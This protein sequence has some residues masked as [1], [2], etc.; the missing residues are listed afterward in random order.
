[1]ITEDC[2]R[3]KVLPLPPKNPTLVENHQPLS[4]LNMKLLNTTLI[5]MAGAVSAGAHAVPV[6]LTP[7]AVPTVVN[8]FLGA[9]RDSDYSFAASVIAADAV[10]TTYQIHCESGLLNMP[11]F[12]T[13]TCD[14]NDPVRCLCLHS[15]RTPA[16]IAPALDRH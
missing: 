6:A 3:Y 5:L 8:L 1:M 12:P 11:G 9:K 13:T 14:Q 4:N 10:A 16:D 15:S 7:E 2:Q